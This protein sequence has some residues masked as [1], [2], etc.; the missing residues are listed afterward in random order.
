M[1]LWLEGPP[2]LLAERIAARRDDPSD[3]GTRVLHLQLG[4]DLGRIDWHRIDVS[5]D[6]ATLA[7]EVRRLI[8]VDAGAP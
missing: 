1:G 3:A 7:T 5:R 4:Y 6:L 8:G 2:E